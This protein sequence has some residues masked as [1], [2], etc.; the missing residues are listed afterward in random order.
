MRREGFRTLAAGLAL[1]AALA[2]AGCGETARTGRSPA[3]VT[4]DLVEWAKGGEETPQWFGGTLPSDVQTKGSVFQDLGRAT[5]RLGLKDPGTTASPTS[6]NAL[7]EVT[8]T[9]YRVQYLR[10]DGRNTQGVDVPYAFDG[11]MTVTVPRQGAAEGVFEVVRIQAKL[12]PPLRNLRGVAGALAIST[13]AEITFYGRDQAGNEVQA[14]GTMSIAFA[15]WAD[16][17]Q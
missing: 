13:L 8:F 12:E 11:A 1:A 2:G 17:E 15:D 9:R 6:P 10:S 16:P 7:N 4:V 14:T 3:Y 5:F